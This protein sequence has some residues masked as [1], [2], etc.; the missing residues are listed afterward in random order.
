M[1][2]NHGGR[3]ASPFTFQGIIQRRGGPKELPP[4]LSQ[5]PAIATPGVLLTL[6]KNPILE[7]PEQAWPGL[8]LL[9]RSLAKVDDVLSVPLIGI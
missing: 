3:Q 7:N 6:W 9:K 4:P 1:F 8:R 2:C 5:P